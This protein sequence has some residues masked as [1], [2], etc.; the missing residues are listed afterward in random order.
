[1]ALNKVLKDVAM[2][3]RRMR[4]FDVFDRPGY[5]THGVPIEF[6]VEQKL[7][8]KS[9]QDIEKY[10]VEKFIREC[11]AFASEYIPVMSDQFADL[12]VWM[13]WKNPYI[14][15][16]NEYIEAAW[17]TFKQAHEKDLLY[18][19]LY[20]V[21]VC[22]HCETAVAFNEIEYVKQTDTS[23]YV[24]FKVKG[25]EN[26][27]LLIWTTTPWSLPGNTGVMVHPKY[28][29]VRA[30]VG[31]EVWI[32]AKERLQQL[33]DA[34][35]A[36][37]TVLETLMG[38]KLVGLEYEPPLAKQMKFPI[39]KNGF[40]VV[41]SDRYVTVEEGTGL[42]HTAPGFGKED[43]E[44]GQKNNLPLRNPINMD[45][46]LKPET[47]KYAGKKARVVDAEIIADLKDAGML[48]YSHA[49]SHDYPVCWR[50]K[51]PLLQMS[52]PQWFFAVSKIRQKLLNHNETVVWV[53]SRMQGRMRGW[54]EGL[55]DWPVSRSRY[56]GTPLPIWVC[57]KC[58]QKTVVGSVAELSKLTKIPKDLDLHKPFIDAITI[59]CKCGGTQHRV[60]FVLDVW[61][62]SGV[63][64]WAALGY[65]A[66]D[67]LFKAFWPAD[68]NIEGT[69]QFRGWWN[70]Q[71]I[72]SQICFD[73]KPFKAVS[74]HGLV[75][76]LGKKKM[77]KSQG[78]TVAPAE[79]I[80]KYSR[81]YLRYYLASESKGDDSVFDWKRFD[82]IHRFFSILGNS[83]NYAALYLDLDFVANALPPAGI[84]AVEDAWLLSRLQGTIE[85]CQKAFE[86]YQFFRATDALESFV[87]DDLSRTYIKLIRDRAKVDPKT[88]SAMM[89]H[90]LFAVL[91]LLSPIC[92]HVSEHF[93]LHG[94][95]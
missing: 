8:F 1:T 77:S 60:P 92:P 24:K 7:G 78:N 42:V 76:D 10:G 84:S 45:G 94:R 13:D 81:D 5:D 62:D 23:I 17:W 6:K 63:S 14:T 30:Q 38:S 9:K 55:S 85:E 20:P 43:F 70:S 50:D 36:G 54:L 88:V 74:V 44:V 59:K 47:G 27:Y 28:E 72:C 93:Y 87:V 12:G 39:E 11:K 18:L 53:P 40:R 3:S 29:Y 67:K 56:W 61:F 4:G 79:V 52:V 21:H 26:E 34:I 16:T 51:S 65:P 95:G 31:S 89:S 73:A 19:G 91:R 46:S 15:Y 25:K 41:P 32:I 71:L 64:S 80:A 68:L 57:E 35:E 58:D 82:D 83:Y 48:V 37:Y 66:S 75:L 22:P 69:D 90:S 33:M 86:S 2:R 49:Y